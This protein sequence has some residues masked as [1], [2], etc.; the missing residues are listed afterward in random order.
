MMTSEG[1]SGAPMATARPR[2]PL[3]PPPVVPTPADLAE[4]ARPGPPVVRPDPDPHH[5]RVTFRW[6]PPP[7]APAPRRVWLDLNGVTDRAHLDAAWTRPTADG[8]GH[9]LT[10]RLPS[11]LRASYAY[12]PL[13][14]DPPARPTGDRTAERRWWLDLLAHAE[15]DPHA[16]EQLPATGWRGPRSVLTLP[17]AAPSD[18]LDA[19]GDLP[20]PEQLHLATLDDPARTLWLHRTPPGP[21]DRAHDPA[22]RPLVLLL[23]GQV[24][25]RAMPLSA[26]VDALVRAGR[27]PPLLLA[28]LDAVDPAR[29]E[30]DL[31]AP[32][33]LAG[34]LRRDVLP[35][36]AARTGW[37]P[38]PARTVLA[39]QSYGGLAAFRTAVEDP[40]TAAR[41]LCQSG[42]F[43]VPGAAD[44]A[45]RAPTAG[46][47]RA[48]LQ[49]GTREGHLTAAARSVRERL[50]VRGAR[51]SVQ[52]VE[53]GHDHAWWRA[54]LLDGLQ[55]LL[56]ARAPRVGRPGP[57]A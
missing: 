9:H 14:G 38:H 15:T 3:P 10:L 29:R 24:W 50:A 31:T 57:T 30:R 44:L 25:L 7:G 37:R 12:L 22:H 42:S 40:A 39:G 26:A 53:G 27:L 2:T 55:Q 54:S 46:D 45:E 34:A 6:T 47:W 19:P 56:G 16:G 18:W 4:H 17:A 23:D 36:L 35:A 21:G 33:R 49:H 11:T 5:V 52:E 8:A 51:C 48:V 32:G 43:W 41:A 13:H 20:A 28:G 1:R